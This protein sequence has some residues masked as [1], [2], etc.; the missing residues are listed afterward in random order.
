M[1]SESRENGLNRIITI[2]QGFPLPLGFYRNSHRAAPAIPG[3]TFRL[4]STSLTNRLK[5]FRC[6]C[7]N[8]AMFYL[9][10]ILA[11]SNAVRY[12]I[13]QILVGM[14]FLDVMGVYRSRCAAL[15]AGKIITFKNRSNPLFIFIS[16]VPFRI[17]NLCGFISTTGAAIFRFW[18]PTSL[19]E[20]SP[21][22]GACSHRGGVSNL[23]AFTGAIDI[24]RIGNLYNKILPADGAGFCPASITEHSF[25]LAACKWLAARLA[26]RRVNLFMFSLIKTHITKV[27][28]SRY[29][30]P[31][32]LARN[33]A[34]RATFGIIAYW[35]KF[36]M[37]P[38]TFFHALIL[39]F[40]QRMSRTIQGIKRRMKDAFPG[41]EIR[42]AE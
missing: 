4:F 2:S 23:I 35:L 1:L 13:S 41:I 19:F 28:S 3:M 29:R 10:A 11:K 40:V 9:M 16:P 33:A 36:I 39:P 27:I 14:P 17:R 25:W 21:T 24:R 32:Y 20:L 38:Y 8:A 7:H 31:T 22:K 26:N 42:R 30:L 34:G 15:L 12:F 5:S 37:A 6:S 18:M